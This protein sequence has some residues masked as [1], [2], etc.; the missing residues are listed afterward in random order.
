[1][2]LV[3]PQKVKQKWNVNKNEKISSDCTVETKIL[4]EKA[5]ETHVLW[6]HM[7]FTSYGRNF[8]K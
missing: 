4:H 6:P 2:F 1:M 8:Y 5:D 3:F 7:R